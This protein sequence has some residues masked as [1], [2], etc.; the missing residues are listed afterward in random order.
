VVFIELLLSQV[1]V[2]LYRE[3]HWLSILHTAP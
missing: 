1:D 3:L 2:N